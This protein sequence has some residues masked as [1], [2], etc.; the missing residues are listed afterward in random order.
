MYNRLLS[1]GLLAAVCLWT[2]PLAAAERVFAV[3]GIVQAMLDDGSPVIA[4]E[5]IPG[6][7]PAM[8]MAFAVADPSVTAALKA[9]DR[10]RFRFRVTDDASIADRFVVTGRDEAGAAVRPAARTKSQRL[11][12]GDAVPAFRLIDEKGGA[13]TDEALRGRLTVATFIF[14]RCPVPEFCPAMAIKFAS[15]QRA[16]AEEPASALPV[17]LL[18]ITLDPEFDRPEVLAAYGRAVGAVPE[19]WGFAT[20][21]KAEIEKLTKAF[22]VFTERNGV[23]LDHTLCTALIGPGGRVI[24]L[25]RG[26]AWEVGE[27]LAAIRTARTR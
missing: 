10:V 12:A 26:N 22:A 25:W 4:H 9:G 14:T 15:L 8:T 3:T 24:E 13:L 11:R 2:S 17:R 21:E 23:T 1:L 19:V 18:G 6:F 20:G 5:A 27:V 16:L 7:M